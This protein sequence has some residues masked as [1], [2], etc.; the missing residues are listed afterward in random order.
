MENIVLLSEIHPMG[1]QIFNP[2]EQ[3]C[4][5]YR[6]VKPGDVSHGYSFPD[7]I[8]L[9]A[10]Q[11]EAAGK[12]LVIRDW[13]HLD[14]IGIPFVKQPEYRSQLQ[15]ALADTFE[16]SAFALVRHPADQWFSTRRL[17][18]M[19]QRLTLETYLA[20]Y[21]RFAERA[22]A[23]GFIRY[24][25]FTVDP[26]SNMR[27]L[28]SNL[29]ITFDPGFVNRWQRNRCVTGDISGMSRGAAYDRITPLERH[30]VDGKLLDKLHANAD[31]CR[32]LELLGYT[33]PAPGK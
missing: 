19:E 20:G 1:T 18:V 4:D 23:Q 29:H 30:P 25:E 32:A 12:T 5:W 21:R 7:T 14:Y 26:V 11:S 2:L 8:R 15:E 22:A 33:D 3:A 9:I 16:V 6:L 31:Y 10:Q 17:K 27:L 28:C 24:E 13:A